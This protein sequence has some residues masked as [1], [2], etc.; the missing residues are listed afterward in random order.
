MTG[1]LASGRR[2]LLAVLLALGAS[3]PAIA[4]EA[5]HVFGIKG[6]V[7]ASG[8][9]GSRTLLKN[10]A[11]F[12]GETLETGANSYLVVDFID[13]AKATLRPNSTLTI[14][15]YR[16]GDTGS[17]ALLDLVRGGL[18]AVTGAIARQQPDNYQVKTP[19]A[20][21]GVRGTEYYLRICEEDCAEEQQL[22]VQNMV[23]QET[24]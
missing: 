19:V 17:E 8:A 16:A 18:R 3:S 15:R 23:E 14:E 9:D 7:T 24:F 2:A 22:Y 6:E 5:G 21:L 20:T 12:V 11:V 13:G 4:A 10:D 1:I